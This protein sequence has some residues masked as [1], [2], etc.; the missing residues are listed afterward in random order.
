M[1]RIYRI[2][3]ISVLT[4]RWIIRQPLWI[5]QSLLFILGFIILMVAWGGMEA[6][7]NFALVLVI[8]GYWTIG[9]NIVAQEYGWNRIYHLD[10]MFIASP[11]TILD[12]FIGIVLGVSIYNTIF[13]AISMIMLIYLG[14]PHIMLPLL[15][16]GLIGLI[17]GSF[18]GLIAV[19]MVKNPT[20]ISAITNPLVTLTNMLPPVYY[21]SV[22]LPPIID[23]ALVMVPTATL[24][25]IA[26]YYTGMPTVISPIE[27]TIILIA[28][29]AATLLTLS[30]LITWGRG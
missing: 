25:E 9:V 21:P 27:A 13:M 15:V 22:V 24:M 3:G 28:W 4:S 23:K 14:I 12:Y 1:R 7:K 8:S 30:R 5:L 29:L 2:I 20:N 16:L 18:I 6:V 26:R 19:L 17:L 10:E 11:V